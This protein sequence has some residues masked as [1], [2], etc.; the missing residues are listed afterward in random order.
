MLEGMWRGGW[1]R[2]VGHTM[3]R[4][5]MIAHSMISL[6]THAELQEVQLTLARPRPAKVY[7]VRVR[8]HFTLH[9]AASRGHAYTAD[10]ATALDHTPDAAAKSSNGL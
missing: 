6:D 1:R 7:R 3:I 4:H 10:A 8:R 5:N 2:H 9:H